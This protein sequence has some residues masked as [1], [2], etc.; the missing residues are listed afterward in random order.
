M[1][2]AVQAVQAGRAVLS[3]GQRRGSSAD[4]FSTYASGVAAQ[5]RS[6]LSYEGVEDAI[7]N[8]QAVRAFVSS[9]L[10]RLIIDALNG[11]LAE[12]GFDDARRDHR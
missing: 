2:Q 3:E 9:D 6:G 7:Y 8:T 5:Q 11:H 4:R 12:K 1:A 10:A